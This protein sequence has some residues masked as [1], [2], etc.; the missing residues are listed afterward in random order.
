MA[1]LNKSLVK[2]LVVATVLAVIALIGSLLYAIFAPAQ[3]QSDDNDLDSLFASQSQKVFES[4]LPGKPVVLP[5]DFAMHP[6]YQHEWWHFFANVKDTHGNEYG[7][8]WNYFRIARDD[9]EH[10]GWDNSQLYFSHVVI[11]TRDHVWREQRMARGGIGLAGLNAKPFRMWIDNWSWSAKDENPFPGRLSVNTDSFALSLKMDQNGQ[12]VI[13]GEQGYQA[14]H[15]LMPVA[16]YNIQAPF[17]KVRG[18]L[19][20]SNNMPPVA[21]EGTAWMSKEW[22]SGLLAEGQR[23]WDWF[24]LELDKDTTLTVSRFRHNLQLP[25]VFG[26]LSNRNGK[27]ITLNESDVMITPLHMMS[28]ANGKLVPLQ[29]NISIPS[30]N[31][32]I[33]TSVLNQ[34]LWLPFALPYWQGPVYS[35]GTHRAHGFMQLT[36]Y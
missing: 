32:N 33:T 12:Y 29:W 14:K 25:Y 26:T 36:G 18:S 11:S 23:G 1:I 2:L 22:G 19:K 30:Q 20:L 15:N 17:I 13:P 21:V 16:S 5:A 4:A 8:Q 24:V 34:H 3:Y 27:V 28:L 10:P 6:D 9:L 35:F 31:I 7:V